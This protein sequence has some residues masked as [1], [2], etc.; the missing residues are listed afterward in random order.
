[1]LGKMLR[2]GE[3]SL[4]LARLA[5]LNVGELKMLLET[6][7][8]ENYLKKDD[9]DD[10]QSSKALQALVGK[11]GHFDCENITKYLREYLQVMELHRVKEFSRIYSLELAIVLELQ[12]KFQI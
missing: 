5:R 1:M 6:L 4:D 7:L 8:K 3:T 10:H 2:G 12:G 9:L 11:S